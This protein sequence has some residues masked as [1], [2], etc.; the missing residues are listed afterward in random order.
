MGWAR[1]TGWSS[2]LLDAADMDQSDTNALHGT[3]VA[4]RRHH[5]KV[6]P[7]QDNQ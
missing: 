2:A 7:E 1:W 4:A 3:Q 6:T 5:R